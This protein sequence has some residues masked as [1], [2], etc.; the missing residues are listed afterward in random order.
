MITEKELIDLIKS[1]IDTEDE[2]NIDSTMDDIAEWDSLGHLSILSSLDTFTNGAA[3][4]I[5]SLGDA[6]SVRDIYDALKKADF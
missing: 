1:A 2:I 5:D 4:E 6:Y 3:S